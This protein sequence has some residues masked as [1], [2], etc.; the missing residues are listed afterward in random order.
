MRLWHKDLIKVLP[1]KQLIGQWR[2]CCAL[3]KSIAE[4]GFPDHLLV[5]KVRDYP[6]THFTAYA[7]EVV[8]EMH[9][10]GISANLGRILT[11][12]NASPDAVS[13]DE[14]FKGWHNRR[15]L[16]Q[17]IC[18]L[19]EK[20]DCGGISDDE[21]L[22]AVRYAIDVCRLFEEEVADE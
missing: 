2:E 4:K 1:D 7:S 16:M 5:K 13:H 8:Q 12:V 6:L 22:K 9:E 15:Y 20:Y 21:W 19:Q 10:R 3:A 14:L 17:C 11:Y 18:N